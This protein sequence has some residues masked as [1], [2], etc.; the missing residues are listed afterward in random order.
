MLKIAIIAKIHDKKRANIIIG[1]SPPKR[2]AIAQANASAA[3]GVLAIMVCTSQNL[4]TMAS[5]DSAPFF[6]L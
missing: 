5:R 2:A 6:A 4:R 3:I 1:I